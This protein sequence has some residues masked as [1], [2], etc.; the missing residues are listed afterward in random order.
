MIGNV[1]KFTGYSR[2]YLPIIVG[3]E[4]N[5]NGYLQHL[6]LIQVL[7]FIS[8]LNEFFALFPVLLC[9]IEEVGVCVFSDNR[10]GNAIAIKHPIYSKMESRHKQQNQTV[11]KAYQVFKEFLCS[12]RTI[13]GNGKIKEYVKMYFPVRQKMVSSSYEKTIVNAGMDRKRRTENW[14]NFRFQP[15]KIRG[16]TKVHEHL[17][18]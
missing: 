8:I 6:L 1:H 10:F 7:N 9:C 2:L 14:T 18:M 5:V 16:F 17:Q 13:S 4:E 11:L 3:K 15:Y 12:M